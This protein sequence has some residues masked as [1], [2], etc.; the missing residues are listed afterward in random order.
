[1]ANMT[2]DRSVLHENLQ[3]LKFKDLQTFEADYATGKG[4]LMRICCR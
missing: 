3:Y 1:M 4:I 2:D